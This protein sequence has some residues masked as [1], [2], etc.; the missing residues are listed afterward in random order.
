MTDLT[1]FDGDYY[2]GKYHTVIKQVVPGTAGGYFESNYFDG[3]Y[4]YDPAN[5]SIFTLTAD[6]ISFQSRWAD[7]HRPVSMSYFTFEQGVGHSSST[8]Y[9][10]NS[11]NKKEG[12]HS[13]EFP[14]LEGNGDG[15]EA[16]YLKSDQVLA[17]GDID[18]KSWVFDFWYYNEYSDADNILIATIGSNTTAP[19]TQPPY[20]STNTIKLQIYKDSGDLKAICENNN[21]T[22]IYLNQNQNN[23]VLT[24]DWNHISVVYDHTNSNITLRLNQNDNSTNWVDRKTGSFDEI[25]TGATNVILHQP[26]WNYNGALAV[27]SR[28]SEVNFD[29]VRFAYDTTS[30]SR[31]VTDVENTETTLLLSRFNN[32]LD[33]DITLNLLANSTLANTSSLS[34][35]LLTVQN[36]IATLT[37]EAN[38][39]SSA[40]NS[41]LAVPQTLDISTSLSAEGVV[42]K[43]ANSNLSSLFDLD[44]AATKTA[45]LQSDN[46]NVVANTNITATI[47]K[48]VSADLSGVFTPTITALAQKQNDITLQSVS[49]VDCSAGIIKQGVS[50]VNSSFSI[51]TDATK[52][53]N[54]ESNLSCNATISSTTTRIFESA[55]TLN[56]QFGMFTGVGRFVSAESNISS[57]FTTD[58]QAL[59]QAV[60]ETNIQ[61]IASLS[62]LAGYRAFANIDLNSAVDINAKTFIINLDQYVYYIPVETR[63]NTISSE[64]RLH[65]VRP[66]IRAHSVNNE[67]RSQAIR[68]EDRIHEVKGT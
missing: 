53:Q 68:K 50:T 34:A 19:V 57:L 48:G 40:I 66:E 47:D 22:Q 30:Y 39:T 27:G 16:F 14:T 6:A 33:D 58:I 52:T 8:N 10:F 31:S 20:T 32:N 38:I 7:T 51:A 67:I 60:A 24:N 36:A 43:Q 2:D 35:S 29:L 63:V 28:S 26:Y 44:T 3:A 5:S 61:V 1:Y 9:S 42:V 41:L 37:S 54:I 15:T 64:T 56:S 13:F 45:L 65:S 21:G 12:S 62:I 55:A 4:F 46:L 25:F 59:K 49:N 11:S 23:N 17:T 18:N